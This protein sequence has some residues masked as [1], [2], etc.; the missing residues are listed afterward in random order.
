MKPQEIAKLADDALAKALADSR[1]ELFNL[2][3][4]LATGQLDD[5]SKLPLVKKDIARIQ[6]E[7]RMREIK[8]EA[9]AAVEAVGAM[10]SSPAGIGKEYNDKL[11]LKEGEHTPWQHH[12]R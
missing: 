11:F 3:F 2:R 7:L 5:T 6:T 12:Y 4:R 10:A 9:E 1:A 8:A